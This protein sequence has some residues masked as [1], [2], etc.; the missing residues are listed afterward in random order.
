MAAP[1]WEDGDQQ[2]A[3]GDA[4]GDHVRRLDDALARC[5]RHLGRREHSAAELRRRLERARLPVAVIDEAIAIVTEQGYLD[6][7]RYARLTAEDRRAIDGWG[8][9]RIRDRLEAAGVERDVI[10]EALSRF[11]SASERAA[12]E[13]LLRRRCTL[14]LADNRQRQR[15]FGILIQRGFD[16]DL[17]YEVVRSAAG[18]LDDAA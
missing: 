15:A 5:Y 1:D 8:V 10:D 9:E 16:S 12:A 6:D 18:G 2:G 11:D 3:D 7:A 13:A 14:P 4:P 17:A